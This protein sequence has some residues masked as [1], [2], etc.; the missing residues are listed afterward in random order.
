MDTNWRAYESAHLSLN[1]RPG[2]FAD[3][4]HAMLTE[5]LEDQYAVTIAALKVNYT[6]RITAFLYTSA[7]D[8]DLESNFS[9]VAYPDTESMRAVA[10]PPLHPNLFSLLSHEMNHVIEQNTLGRPGTYFMN[11]GLPS[12]VISTRFN[13]SSIS[14]LW[15]WTASHASA[16]PSLDVLTNDEKWGGTDIEYKAAASFLAYLLDRAGPTPVARLYQVTSPQFAKRIQEIYGRTLA[17]L[18]RDWR[19]FCADRQSSTERPE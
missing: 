11:E 3:E 13:A 6:G 7:G 1:V 14:F 15:S 18:D 16:I 17:D 9:G 2:S 12:A 8:A 10:A 5:V 4:Q 19:V